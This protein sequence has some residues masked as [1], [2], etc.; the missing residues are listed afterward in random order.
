[1]ANPGPPTVRRTT[2]FGYTALDRANP[3]NH[4]VAI[5]AARIRETRG[6]REYLEDLRSVCLDDHVGSCT[7]GDGC[8]SL[9]VDPRY[10]LNTR[11]PQFPTCCAMHGDTYTIEHMHLLQDRIYML[12]LPPG[13]VLLPVWSLSL[14]VSLPLPTHP[15]SPVVIRVQDVCRKHLTGDCRFSKECNWVHICRT[16]MSQWLNNAPPPPPVHVTTPTSVAQPFGPV[17]VTTQPNTQPYHTTA[18]FNTQFNTTAP[19]YYVA[20]PYLPPKYY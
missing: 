13:P 17:V 9:H 18:S 19:T 20:Y 12:M 8:L 1:M 16:S 4:I 15:S 10:L 14:T 6:S 7:R 3:F 5:P 2:L 11:M